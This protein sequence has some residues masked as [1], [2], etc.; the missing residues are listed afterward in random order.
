M[1]LLGLKMPS[2]SSFSLSTS[3]VVGSASTSTT[4]SVGIGSFSPYTIN[5]ERF[6]TS[7]MEVVS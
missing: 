2:S 3:A 1:G 6:I 5:L 4:S 7:E